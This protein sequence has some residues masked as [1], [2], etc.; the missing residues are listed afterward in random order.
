M[1]KLKKYVEASFKVSQEYYTELSEY[2]QESTDAIR[3]IKAYSQEGNQLKEF[4]RKIKK[5]KTANDS[6]D[7][8]STLLTTLH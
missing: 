7:V 5:I 8:H 6:V 1:L 2:V 4:I 3:T